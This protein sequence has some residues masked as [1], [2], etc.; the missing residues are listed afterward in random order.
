MEI[1]RTM[2]WGKFPPRPVSFTKMTGVHAGAM[3]LGVRSK[4]APILT[5]GHPTLVIGA[6]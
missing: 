2:P 5:P 6:D 4:L 1:A 3:H